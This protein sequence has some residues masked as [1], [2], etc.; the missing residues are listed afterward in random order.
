M[1]FLR[2]LKEQGIIRIIWIAGE[3]NEADLF[4]KNLGGPAF[5]KHGSV[6]YGQDEYYHME[7]MQRPSKC[8]RAFRDKSTIPMV[9]Q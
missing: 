8:G 4:T 5:N 2:D 9:L 6:Y 3:E 7:L 1:N